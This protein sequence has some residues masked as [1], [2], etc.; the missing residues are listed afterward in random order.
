MRTATYPPEQI[1]QHFYQDKVLTIAELQRRSGCSRMTAWRALHEHGYYTSYNHNAKFYTLADIPSFDALGLWSF[2]R[3][4]FS[5]YGSLTHTLAGFVDASEA[6]YTAQE[7]CAVLGMPVGPALSR[8]HAQTR[9]QR[10]R[11]GRTFVY[12]AGESAQR[13]MQ[14]EHRRVQHRA[15]L[16]RSSLPEPERIIPVLVELVRRPELQPKALTT[17]LRRRGVCLTV[18]EVQ[19]IF[20]RY[21]LAGKRGR[22]SC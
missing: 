8:L 14:M 5:R 17:R 6:G 18:A 22:W 13:A 10:E 11:V 19:A 16:E 21:D 20:T 3:I 9:V 2:Q 15:A 1:L 7:L 12:V 4:R